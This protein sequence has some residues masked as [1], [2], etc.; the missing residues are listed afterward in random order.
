AKLQG[1]KARTRLQTRS[2]KEQ[3]LLLNPNPQSNSSCSIWT[4]SYQSYIKCKTGVRAWEAC[5]KHGGPWKSPGYPELFISQSG[6]LG[7]PSVQGAADCG[8]RQSA[9]RS[10]IPNMAQANEKLRKEMA[11]APPGRFNIENIDGTHGKVIQM[12]VTLFEIHQ[13]DSKE[14]DSSEE[15][16]QDSSENSS[17]SEDEDDSIPSEVIIDNIKLPYSEGGK[18]KIEVLDSPASKKKK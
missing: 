6:L 15:T 7:G 14:A 1:S 13:L 4:D 10:S 16:S 3:Q 12:D 17:E 8:K 9:G 11:A 18:G 5:G 2:S